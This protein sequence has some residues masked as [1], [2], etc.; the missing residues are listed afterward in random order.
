MTEQPVSSPAPATP[1]KQAAAPSVP[2]E[3]PKAKV[4]RLRGELAKAE[5]ALPPEPGT[6][7]VKVEGPHSSFSFGSA[8]V[9]TDYTSVPNHLVPSLMRAASE[10]GVTLTTEG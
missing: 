3:D 8:V 4:E 2:A 5:A 10:A 6:V 9:G 1:G 7:R